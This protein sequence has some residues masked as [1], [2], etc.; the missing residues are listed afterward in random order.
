MNNQDD[1]NIFLII[2]NLVYESIF[3]M[4]FRHTEFII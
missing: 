4:V 2:S 1:F 3:K